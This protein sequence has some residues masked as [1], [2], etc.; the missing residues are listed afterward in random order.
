[1]KKLA[2]S[3]LALL[4][5]ASCDTGTKPLY[6][7][8]KEQTTKEDDVVQLIITDDE[9][10]HISKVYDDFNERTKVS[11]IGS[12]KKGNFYLEASYDIVQNNILKNRLPKPQ[13]KNFLLGI[14]AS[15][16]G[17]RDVSRVELT[18]NNSTYVFRPNYTKHE[19]NGKFSMIFDFG[20]ML[21]NTSYPK[22][23]A[24]AD[25]AEARVIFDNG[26]YTY[27]LS[28]DDLKPVSVIYRSYINDGG[29][30]E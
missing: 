25:H 28:K 29:K 16:K 9:A 4:A 14:I 13:A 20:R 17:A 6:D 19:G 18:I 10:A 1:M 30:I 7:L 2:L 27:E 11:Y 5:F 22:Y 8:S 3:L 15:R 21:D 24:F 12:K 26:S 23:I